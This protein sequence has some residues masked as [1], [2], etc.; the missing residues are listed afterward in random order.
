MVDNYNFSISYSVSDS[1]P[2][3]TPGLMRDF[4]TPETAADFARR[5]APKSGDT[6]GIEG[7]EL[8]PTRE[9]SP[10]RKLVS[11]E[12][13]L[14]DLAAKRPLN[15]RAELPAIKAA[16]ALAPIPERGGL[17]ADFV[18]PKTQ[19]EVA[20]ARAQ[21]PQRSMGMSYSM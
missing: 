4:V 21:A 2:T 20:T 12:E 5:Q 16:Q 17:L 11:P 6:G 15:I 14:K 3:S 8:T 13:G 18:T 19:K 1:K 10:G 7:M 9:P